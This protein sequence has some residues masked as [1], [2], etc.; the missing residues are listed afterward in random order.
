MLMVVH[1]TIRNNSNHQCITFER[2]IRA[3]NE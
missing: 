1:C 3:P 2:Q